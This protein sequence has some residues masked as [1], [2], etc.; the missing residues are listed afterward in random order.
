VLSEQK[1]QKARR[2]KSS[3]SNLGLGH[4]AT[5]QQ[6]DDKPFTSLNAS[7]IPSIP[8]SPMDA[9]NILEEEL[10]KSLQGLSIVIIHVK[11]ALFPA[12]SAAT[13]K[14]SVASAGS[15]SSPGSLGTGENGETPNPADANHSAYTT[16]LI[17]PR[18]MQERI[19]EELEELEEE[20]GLG[21]RFVMA[22]QG[23]RIEC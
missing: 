22:K 18:T 5:S 23:M 6:E 10:R 8:S 16:P 9:S 15:P 13:T 4:G 14:G 7:Q 1:R 19:L 11:T 17:D 21:V 3:K 12:Y 20:A 2:Q